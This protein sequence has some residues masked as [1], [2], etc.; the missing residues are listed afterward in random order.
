MCSPEVIDGTTNATES[1]DDD[2]VGEDAG[3]YVAYYLL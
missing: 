2:T 3:C 1:N